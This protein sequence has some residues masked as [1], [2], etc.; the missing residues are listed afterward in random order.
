M[1]TVSPTRR[2]LLQLTVGLAA[3]GAVASTH[4]LDVDLFKG[5]EKVRGN[6]HVV[7]QPRAA[8]NFNGVAFSLPGKLDIKFGT[9]EGVTVETDDNLQAYI[10]TV[11]E[12]GVLKVRAARRNLN[13]ST[14]SLK[15]VVNARQIESISLAGSGDIAADSLRAPQLRV[16]LAGSG[17]IHL[18]GVDTDAMS[19]SLGGSGNVKAGGGRAERLKVS[20]AGSGDVVLGQLQSASA[21]VSIA[22]SGDATVWVRNALDVSIAGSGDV[23]YYGAPSV[24]KSAIG[25]GSAKPLGAAPR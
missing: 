15:I 25:S 23:N 4:A 17:D 13:F 1:S 10:E 5:G 9:A 8:S 22:G 3:I 7:V 21:S 24:N 16:D 18:N 11:V 19:V 6:G 2:A 12:N 20:I 14:K